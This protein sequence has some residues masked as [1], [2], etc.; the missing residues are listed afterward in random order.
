MTKSAT[1]LAAMCIAA[2]Y[3]AGLSAKTTHS[4]TAQT[5]VTLTE[6]ADRL[7]MYKC[8]SGEVAYEVSL[9]NAP[10]P[11]TYTVGLL[12]VPAD[13]DTL[14][15][16]SYLLD[17]VL[18]RPKGD[19]HGFA[20]YSDGNHYRYR[21]LKLQEYHAA[22]DPA[23]FRLGEGVQNQA[24]FCEL[25]PVYMAGTLRTMAGDSTYITQI[26]SNPSG[27]CVSGKR[28]IQGFDAYDYE[29][30]F[31][32]KS[33]LPVSADF[34]YNPASITEQTV[35]AH[36][37]WD[38]DAVCPAITEQTLIDR[39]PE[40]FEKFRT[41]NFRVESLV[42]S[43]LPAFAAPTLDGP[44]FIHHR[45]EDL[46]APTVIVFMDSTVESAAAT[47]RDM[48]QAVTDAP[49]DFDI[50]YVFADTDKEPAEALVT[51]PRLP[52]ETVL[53]G[54]RSLIRDAG[55]TA[56]P[57]LLYVN[58]DGTVNQVNTAYNKDLPDVVIMQMSLC[59]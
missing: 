21:D 20:A 37:S 39:Y 26:R 23:P 44:R 35:T 54:A 18:P 55:V 50:L 58:G 2:I 43:R 30:V 11:V 38:T 57:T 42:G 59:R 49:A 41:S 8:I 4:K 31:D 1:I 47:V 28:V 24:R 36:F 52:N 16:C 53:V 32:P 46:H 34:I 27:L 14:A 10:D 6:I 56:Y 48:R 29:Y 19:S 17:W 33:L 40:I 5:P 7:S 22:V 51:A 45:G 13:G 3:P 25:L 15:P 12:S 9:P